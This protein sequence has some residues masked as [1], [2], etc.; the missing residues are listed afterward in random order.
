M[1]LDSLKY[2]R[3]LGENGFLDIT[4]KPLKQEKYPINQ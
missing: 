2:L 4:S 3:L 1:F